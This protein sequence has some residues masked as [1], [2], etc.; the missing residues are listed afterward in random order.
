MFDFLALLTGQK[1]VMD[2]NP[3]QQVDFLLATNTFCLIRTKLYVF[4]QFRIFNEWKPLTALFCMNSSWNVTLHTCTFFFLGWIGSG[5]VAIDSERHKCVNAYWI[6]FHQMV[7]FTTLPLFRS[8]NFDII[9]YTTIKTF[10]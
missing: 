1:E 4:T 8:F 3:T 7:F 2:R 9:F 5:I 10:N 6:V